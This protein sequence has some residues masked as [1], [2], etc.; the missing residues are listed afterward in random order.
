MTPNVEVTGA[1]PLLGAASG[2]P[3]GYVSFC[4]GK[5]NF[6]QD[7][8][9][10]WFLGKPQFKHF[11]MLD[12]SDTDGTRHYLPSC[13]LISH[14]GL[15]LAGMASKTD[16]FAVTIWMD[17]DMRSLLD[18]FGIDFFRLTRGSE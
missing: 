4:I 5:A 2:V 14:F 3:Q 17:C 12:R 7:D 15:E 10:R 9:S 18:P 13:E 16:E 8:S 1:A 6:L 11:L